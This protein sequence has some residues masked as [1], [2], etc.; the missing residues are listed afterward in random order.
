MLITGVGTILIMLIIAVLDMND[1]I[2]YSTWLAVPYLLIH[3]IG[4]TCCYKEW[5]PSSFMKYPKDVMQ[6]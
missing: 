4:A 3:A 6:F 1:K 2:E 5:V